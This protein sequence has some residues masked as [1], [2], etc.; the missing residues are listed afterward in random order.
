MKSRL[1]FVSIKNINDIV[2]SSLYIVF[3]YSSI[4]NYFVANTFWHRI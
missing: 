3:S 4:N 2:S 1:I